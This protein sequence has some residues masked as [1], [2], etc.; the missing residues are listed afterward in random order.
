MFLRIFVSQ[1]VHERMTKCTLYQEDP[2]KLIRRL[3]DTLLCCEGSEV[4]MFCTSFA[5]DIHHLY[6]H[7]HE[8]T[9]GEEYLP[10]RIPETY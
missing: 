6:M 7:A 1:L 4:S 3:V 10:V 8:L 5:D 9:K 2:R